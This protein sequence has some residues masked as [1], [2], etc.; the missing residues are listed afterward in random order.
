MATEAQSHREKQNL[1]SLKQNIALSSLCLCGKQHMDP[2]TQI[3]SRAVPLPNDNVDTDQIV[4][5]RF[6]KVTDKVGMDQYLFC[7]WR[8]NADGSPK[9]DF[10]LNQP[11]AKGAK[12]LLVGSNFGTGSSREHAPW[13][14]VAFG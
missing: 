8:F 14:L 10:I 5:A 13:A 11:R 9:P 1:F 3:T 7:D 12:I 2:F 6:L 4:P